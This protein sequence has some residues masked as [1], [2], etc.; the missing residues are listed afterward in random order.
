M[1]DGA[2]GMAKKELLPFKTNKGI[3]VKKK[4]PDDLSL[5]VTIK[6]H[7]MPTERETI[8]W[9]RYDNSDVARKESVFNQWYE[10]QVLNPAD[11]FVR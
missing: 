11:F 7:Q 6:D 9:W 5:K 4:Y 10:L 8:L 2:K 3:V 1:Q